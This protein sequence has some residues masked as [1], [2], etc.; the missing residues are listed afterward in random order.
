M[1]PNHSLRADDDE[2]LFPTRPKSARE[3]SEQFIEQVESRSRMPALEDSKLLAK[4]MAFEQQAPPSTK[5]TKNEGQKQT[6]GL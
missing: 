2:G 4:Q 5:T 1:P 3:N 6:K